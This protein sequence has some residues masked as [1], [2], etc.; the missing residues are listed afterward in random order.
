MGLSSIQPDK[1]T[2]IKCLHTLVQ[3]SIDPNI[4]DWLNFVRCEQTFLI[5][6]GINR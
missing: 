6:T 2:E 5:Y 4:G 3:N 1:L